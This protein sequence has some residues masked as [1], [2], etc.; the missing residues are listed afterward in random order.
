MRSTVAAGTTAAAV[1]LCCA[2]ACASA[3]AEVGVPAGTA[4]QAAAD[5]LFLQYAPAPPNPGIV[6]LVDSGV[7]PTPDTTPIL[8][9]NYALSPNTNTN[10]ELAALDPPLLGGHPDGHGTYMAMIAAAPANGWGIVV[11]AAPC[12]FSR[13]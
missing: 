10:D 7:D 8:A 2:A 6:C 4:Q 12:A 13:R 1:A 9:G 5:A 3:S 11:F